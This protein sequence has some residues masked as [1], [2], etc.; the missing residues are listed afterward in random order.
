MDHR[1]DVTLYQT[2]REA[3]AAARSDTY[4]RGKTVL[5]WLRAIGAWILRR[6]VKND[7]GQSPEAD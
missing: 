1:D 6:V 5:R 3:N 4:A 2:L 7:R